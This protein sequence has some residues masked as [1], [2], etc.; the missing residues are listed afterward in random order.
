MKE[1][2]LE[3]FIFDYQI[4]SNL[5]LDGL[6]D[7]YE[8]SPKKAG[9][10]VNDLGIS[11]VDKG[12]KDSTNVDILVPT[13]IPEAI[14]YLNEL[15]VAADLYNKL[16]TYSNIKWGL[17]EAFTIQKYQPGG[18]YFDWHFERVGP[19]FPNVNRY[20]V[21]MTYLNDVADEGYTE[22]FYQKLKVVPKKGLTL[23]WPAEWTHT[24]RGVP[25][26][27]QEKIIISGWLNLI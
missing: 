7:L 3:N 2:L 21:F 5:I 14:A 20:L 19:K 6:I 1:Y 12:V 17:C 10:T 24:H 13:I 8:R 26:Q 25:S 18:A 15:K 9:V 27:T 11:S 23:I 4:K 22:F 16:Y